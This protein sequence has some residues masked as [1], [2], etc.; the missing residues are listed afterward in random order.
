[1]TKKTN[2]AI[3]L[4]FGA[5]FQLHA[6][7]PKAP[8]HLRCFDKIDPVGISDSPFFGWFSNDP[9]NNEIQ[10]AYQ[11]IV[12][13][14][15][16]KIDS[17]AGDIWDSGKIKS[18]S[19]NYV[20][21]RGEKLKPATQYFWKVRTWDKDGNVGPYSSSATFATGLFTNNDWHG[22]NWIKRD[23]DEPDDYT[24]FRK[25]I[26]LP[27]KVVKRA[28]VYIAACHDYE[29]Y[30]NG[31]FVGKGFNHHYPQYSYYNAWDITSFLNTNQE[32]L[33][34]CLTHWYGGG[35]GRA[36]G[37]R[38]LLVKTIIEYTD[39]T[40]TLINSDKTWKQTQ[41][42]QW[43][44]GQAQRNGEGVGRVEKIDS[45]KTI[46]NWNTAKADDSSWE[47]ATEIGPH[48]TQPWTGI[49]QA[50]LT[51]VIEEEIKPLSVSR[52]K[53]GKYVI[54]LGKITAGNFKINFQGGNAGD[55]I[56][57]IGGYVLNNDGTVSQK[58]NQNTNLNFFFIHNGEE[59]IFK[60]H[61]YLGLRYLEVENAPDS[62]KPS[63]VSFIKR[64][65]ELLP[66][67]SYFE[68]SDT[69]L[70]EVW[71]LMVYSLV[72]GAQEDFVDTPTREKGAF[73]GDSWLQGVPCLSVLY[74]RTM[75]LRTLNEFLDSQE[76]FWPDGRLNAVYPNADG[77][78]DIPDYTQ[79][80][81]FWVWDYYMQTGNTEFLQTNYH[82]LKMIA[83]YVDS[84]KNETTGLIH[85]L[86]GG[87]NQYEYGIIDWP[88]DM[89]YG[90]DM[91][92]ESRTVINAY[93]YAGFKIMANIAEILDKHEDKNIY[94]TKALDIK[95]AI[96]TRLISKNGVYTDGI[97][98]D[99]S[100]SKN[101]SQHANIVPLALQ[102][103]PEEYKENIIH[104]I[105]KREISVGMIC[106]RWL[107]EAIGT[108]DEGEHLIDLYTNPQWDGW[109]KNLTQGA[110][111]TW[112]SWNA[113]E[114]N[115]SLS[116][117]WGA[118]GLLAI[119]NYILG[120]KSLSPQNEKVQ[121]KPLDFGDKLSFA[122]GNYTT[123]RGVIF[124][125]WQKD[126]QAYTMKIN[127][128]N[129]V[130]ARVYVP[131]NNKSSNTLTLNQK[132]VEGTIEGNYIYLDNIGSGEYI[133]ER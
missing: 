101:V 28:V 37:E 48:P 27:E 132:E 54:D 90:Y 62:L 1:M 119:Q 65:Y 127:I 18:R 112:E 52:L 105:K 115:Q 93:A 70:N 14:N 75:N 73:L 34:A 16:S 56:K 21:Y 39:S 107:T 78:R 72:V 25:K 57:M 53:N 100:T 29:L 12:S 22:A 40:F 106:I 24:Y 26:A 103:A 4:I 7:N 81:L 38:G 97:Y 84:C 77:A 68:S 96:N 85:N 130:I 17:N 125:D 64:H 55:T 5:L 36:K 9:D 41:A 114:V 95:Q 45:R 15:K 11:I 117:P 20:F 49:L 44:T 123:D 108:A 50:D 58:I 126:E 94:S 82:R 8:C 102:I 42:K 13:S 60:S 92:A 43:I 46:K 47:F 113:L 71:K 121:I 61:V 83:D 2:I 87:A 32:N 67:K 86:K 23:T 74:D 19:Q 10:S 116:H 120:I 110:T 80:Y 35:Q 89:R 99:K 30:I 133:I 66:H 33:F 31:K 122:R 104:E 131:N 79:M 118:V 59:A 111:V 129:N 76:Q 91:N 88:P 69:T 109:A 6:E 51:R 124:V 98:A 3:M 128:P 63:D